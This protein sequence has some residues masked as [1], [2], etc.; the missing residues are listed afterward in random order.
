MPIEFTYLES[1]V[2]LSTQKPPFSPQD[3]ATLQAEIAKSSPQHDHFY[4][5]SDLREVNLT[6]SEIVEGMAQS[7][8]GSTG[9]RAG[10]SGVEVIV[11]TDFE[12]NKMLVEFYKQEQYG[13]MEMPLFSTLDD[14]KSYIAAKKR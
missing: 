4:V 2:L 12:T 1:N 14:A 9:Y 6:F 3:V 10:D 8:D 5:I 7:N 11:L 13:S